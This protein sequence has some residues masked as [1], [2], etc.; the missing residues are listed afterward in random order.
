MAEEHTA[1]G[2]PNPPEPQA[3]FLLK[4]I[5]R[6]QAGDVNETGFFQTDDQSILQQAVLNNEL[7]ADR[8]IEVPG[9][10]NVAFVDGDLNAA[11]TPDAGAIGNVIDN[12][13]GWTLGLEGGQYIYSALLRGNLRGRFEIQ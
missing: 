11:R 8:F 10:P 1:D 6:D 2:L 5:S 3:F 12:D 4:E 7:S 13:T 9:Q